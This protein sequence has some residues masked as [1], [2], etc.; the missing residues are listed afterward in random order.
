MGRRR[1]AT[2][3]SNEHASKAA[4][5]HAHLQVDS[6]LDVAESAHSQLEAFL[7]NKDK[8]PA[9]V[10][11]SVRGPT[12]A[13]RI[14][15]FSLTPPPSLQNHRCLKI[16]LTDGETELAAIEYRPCRELYR[17]MLPGT[18]VHDGCKTPLSARLGDVTLFPARVRSCWWRQEPA[19]GA[20]CCF[21]PQ[22]TYACLA[23]A[24]RARTGPL[25]TKRPCGA[26]LRPCALWQHAP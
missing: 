5:A 17:E 10:A 20:D 1:Q 14:A 12:A 13:H 19:F 26:Y 16:K 9:R 21:W 25:F 23:A 8:Q 15:P 7:A 2:E 11:P 4:H 24:F 3:G 6:V 22:N 18:K